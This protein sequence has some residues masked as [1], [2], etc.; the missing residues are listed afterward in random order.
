[1]KDVTVLLLLNER[2]R[3]IT[4][5][6]KSPSP[7]GGTNSKLISVCKGALAGRNQRHALMAGSAA[8]PD[9]PDPLDY[10]AS[11]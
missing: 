7:P 5:E 6:L 9:N 11:P 10:E 1:M 8:C 4:V 3:L 2:R